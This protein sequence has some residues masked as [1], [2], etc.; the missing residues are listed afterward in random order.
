[1]IDSL[2]EELTELLPGF[3]EN[4]GY[5]GKSIESHSTGNKNRETGKTSDPDADWGK[6][7]YSGVDSSG[8]AWT[9]IKRWFGYGLHIIADTEYDLPVAFSLTKA[10]VSEV[11]ELDRM[12]DALLGK[13]PELAKRCGYLSADRGLDSGPLKKKLWDSWRIRPVIDNRELWREEK[14]G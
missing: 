2:R 9:K 7:E 3:G 4:L 13:S 1:M 10:S 12:T 11:K 14:K 6:H 5:D 8:K